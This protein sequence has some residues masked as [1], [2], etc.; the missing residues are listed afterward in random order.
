MIA[1]GNGLI[2]RPRH[3]RRAARR[4][5]CRAWPHAASSWAPSP[6]RSPTPARTSPTSPAA[7]GSDGDD[8]VIT[9]NKYWCTF[10]DG[11]DLHHAD[12][13]H[14]RCARSGK[15]KHVGLSVV[16]GR[17]AARHAAAGR[18]GRAD[19]QDRLFRLEDLGAR[20]RQLPRAGR[21]HDRRGRPAPSTTSPPGSRRARAHTAA[22][23]IGLAQ[24]A[25]ED[26]IAYAQ[27]R[28]QFGQADRRLPGDPLQDR[29]AWR[30]RSRRRASSCTSSASR[31]T[32]ASAA[33]RRRR[34]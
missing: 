29:R 32:P 14:L 34:W 21:R 26:A 20:L 23:S 8:W 5:T 27:E 9:G 22:R 6:C 11:A 2:G 18:E 3:E 1:R 25:L 31:S 16:P 17:E 33:T 10:A 24:G 19:P 30:P 7:P 13:A 15:R 12:R 4:V 28:R